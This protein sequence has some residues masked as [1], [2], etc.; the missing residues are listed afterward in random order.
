MTC[1]A[2]EVDLWH[3]NFVQD[4]RREGNRFPF[5]VI[6]IRVVD[7][8]LCLVEMTRL[9]D[10]APHGEHIAATLMCQEDPVGLVAQVEHGFAVS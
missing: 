9:D 7:P 5:V 8:V 4:S 2:G 3:F 6:R 10:D 1:L